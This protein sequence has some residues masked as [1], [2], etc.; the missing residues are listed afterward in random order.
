MNDREK[1]I[2]LLENSPSLDTT[3]G[4]YE[5]DADWLIANGVVVREKGEWDTVFY[6]RNGTLS[7]Y[8]HLCP[9]CKYFYRDIRFKGHD[10]C[11]NCGAY[12][13]KGENV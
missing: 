8:S 10:F 5:L 9:K 6:E 2:E 1:L 4:D 7:S 12:M 11:P 13:R 3:Y